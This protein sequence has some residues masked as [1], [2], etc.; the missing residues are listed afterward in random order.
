MLLRIDHMRRF[1]V[2][3]CETYYEK[4]DTNQ[5]QYGSQEAYERYGYDAQ[6][7]SRDQQY[8]PSY[9]KVLSHLDFS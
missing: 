3:R 2:R 7:Y 4:N 6:D 5:D 8:D 9:C 1:V